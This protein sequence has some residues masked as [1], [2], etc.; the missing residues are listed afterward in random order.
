MLFSPDE[1]TIM[2]HYEM[3]FY[4][5]LALKSTLFGVNRAI[6]CFLMTSVCLV[7]LSNPFTFT[8]LCPF[9]YVCFVVH[10]IKCCV[11]IQ[12]EKF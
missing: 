6:N 12:F 5:V 4:L 10:T 11:F 9:I 2:N 8:Y 1:S 7:Y 3:S